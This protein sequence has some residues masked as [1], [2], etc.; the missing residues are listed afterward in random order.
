MPSKQRYVV[1]GVLALAAI[2]GLALSHGL[3][4]IWTEA[5]LT[6]PLLFGLRELSL[7]TVLGYGIAFG[8]AAFVLKHGPTHALALEIVEELARVTWPSREETGNATLV[9]IVTVLV[10]SAY[11]GVFDAFWLWVTDLI[12]GVPAA[13]AG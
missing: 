10:C 11:L 13:T 2:L 12:L 9:V 6:D 1:V 8:A 4:W 7:T 3:Q 5:N